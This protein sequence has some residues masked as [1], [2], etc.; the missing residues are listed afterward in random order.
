MIYNKKNQNTKKKIKIFS[1]QM[2][3]KYIKKYF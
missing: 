3:K 1:L 2:N